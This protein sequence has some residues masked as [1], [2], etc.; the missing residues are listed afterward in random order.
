VK[1]VVLLGEGKALVAK[2]KLF[3]EAFWVDEMH[4]CKPWCCC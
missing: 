2:A 1:F 3:G 4:Y